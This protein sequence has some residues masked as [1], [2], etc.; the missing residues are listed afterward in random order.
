[1]TPFNLP[2]FWLGFFVGA[3]V[4]TLTATLALVVHYVCA[5]NAL[6]CG[7]RRTK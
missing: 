7:D 3:F 6:R 5:L 1:M 4:A 2:S